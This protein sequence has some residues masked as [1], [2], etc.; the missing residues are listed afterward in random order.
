MEAWLKQYK[1]NLAS[2]NPWDQSP[3]L[4]KIKINKISQKE[5]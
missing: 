2:A 3:V 1:Y 5:F 4:P